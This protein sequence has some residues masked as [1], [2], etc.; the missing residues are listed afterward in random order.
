MSHLSK[1]ITELRK[2]KGC[3]QTLIASKLDI[4]Q[5][6]YAAWE[7]G[8]AEPPSEM[9]VAIADLHGVTVDELLRHPVGIE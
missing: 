5:K 1:R 8:R 9:L 3:T 7:E 4:P 6:R 2:N